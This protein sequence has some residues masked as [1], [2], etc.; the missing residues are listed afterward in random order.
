MDLG[1]EGRPALVAAASRGL[2]RAAALSLAREGSPVAICGRD[3]ERL[4]ATRDEIAR[5]SG[6]TVVAIQADVSRE[7]D[8]IRFV[9]EGAD[10]VGGCQILVTNAGGPATGRFEELPPDGFREGMDLLFFSA[11]A[12]AREAIPRMREAS[13]GRIVLLSS[14]SVKEPIR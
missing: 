12:M 1:L 3:P 5:E 6:G 11:L 2:G 14:L 13:Y 8:A 4:E 9:R 7:E 10:A